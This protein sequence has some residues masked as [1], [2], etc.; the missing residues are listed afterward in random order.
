MCPHHD[1]LP[2]IAK[3]FKKLII[4]QNLH[5]VVIVPMRGAGKIYGFIGLNKEKESIPWQ[6]ET[7]NRLTIF[8]EIL[9][10]LLYRQEISQEIDKL[11]S[12]GKPDAGWDRDH[13]FAWRS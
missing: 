1:V 6:L 9:G 11:V 7:V 13:K 4:D 12:A 2:P 8:G 3:A 10:N 5:S